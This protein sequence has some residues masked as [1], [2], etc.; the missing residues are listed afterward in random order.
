MVTWKKRK[1]GQPMVYFLCLFLFNTKPKVESAD[2]GAPVVAQCVKNPTSIHEDA[3]SVL[4]LTQW[5]RIQCCSSF[6][7]G[8]RFSLGVVLVWLWCRPI[9]ALP[10]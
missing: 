6:G 7:M 1:D 4:G 5:L 10:I 3:D 2:R 9:A 8:H